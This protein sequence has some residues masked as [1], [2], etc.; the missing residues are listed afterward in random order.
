MNLFLKI[1]PYL[2]IIALGL[3]IYY[4]FNYM[5]DK[6]SE[7]QKENQYLNIQLSS[8]EKELKN[9]NINYQIILEELEQLQKNETESINNIIDNN[10]N[11]DNMNMTGDR[12]KLLNKINEYEKCISENSLKPHIKCNIDL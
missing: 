4:G 11:I 12:K 10:K 6:I 5:S 1:A 7:V 8:M 9:K 2:I 3:G